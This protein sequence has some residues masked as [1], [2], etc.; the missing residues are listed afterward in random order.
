MAE[1]KIKVLITA[2][3]GN[4]VGYQLIKALKLA[5]TTKYIIYGADTKENAY[6]YSIVEK[7]V[8]LPN[9]N[10]KEYIKELLDFCKVNDIDVLL[11]G[12][13]PEIKVLSGYRDLIKKNNIFMPI[14]SQK[15]LDICLDKFLTN[16]FL[17]KNG[18]NYPI[19]KI[20]SST[21]EIDSIDFFPI[22]LKPSVGG[23]GSQGVQIA[24]NALQLKSIIDYQNEVNSNQEYMVQ[25]YVGTPE[26]EYTCG[27]LFDMNGV[28]INTIVLKRDL[29]SILSQRV[30]E[31]NITCK[32]NLGDNLIISSGVSQGEIGRF[33]HIGKICAE[34]GKKIGSVSTI[35]IQCRYFEKKLY[36]FEINPRF[37]G[38]SSLRAMVGFNE[39]DILIRQ[40]FF[41]ED[42]ESYFNYEE[43]TI[44]RTLEESFVNNV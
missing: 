37:S 11:P 8:V 39:A 1:K 36:V 20:I 10:S 33:E 2:I 38:T 43:A 41:K 9:C 24:Q 35:N 29:S 14:T 42:I 4:S 15:V 12:C 25:E 13:E 18:F 23:G 7:H 3:G 22:V 44:T 32:K 31:K 40:H 17:K 5:K 16:D 6:Q 19:T 34:I 26:D 27:V 21:C 30:V 28:F